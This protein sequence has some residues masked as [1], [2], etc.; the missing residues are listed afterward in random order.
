MAS[1]QDYNSSNLPVDVDVDADEKDEGDD[2]VN[3]QVKIYEIYL[4]VERVRP[5]MC[6]ME[7]CVAGVG[8]GGVINNNNCFQFK[9]LRGVVYDRE[10]NNGQNIE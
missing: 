10:N 6:W 4:D 2:T 7:Q 1:G 5:Q 9:E 3:H 8:C